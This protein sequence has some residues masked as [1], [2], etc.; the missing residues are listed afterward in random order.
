MLTYN[1]V[2]AG[3]TEILRRME[4]MESN[5]QRFLSSQKT[6]K[7]DELVTRQEA[8]DIL[9][10]TLPTL[11]SWTLDGKIVGYRIGRR[12]LYKR[13][14]IDQAITAISGNKKTR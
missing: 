14:E 1:E 8:A 12:V 13:N 4:S 7:L 11:H 10:T 3:I 9:H 5:L 2:P 6:Q